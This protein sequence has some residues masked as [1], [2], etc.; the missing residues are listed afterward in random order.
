MSETRVKRVLL[1]EDSADDEHLTLR[2]LAKSAVPHHVDVARDG[3]EAVRYIEA[4]NSHSDMPDLILLDLKLPKLNGI[5]VLKRI[6]ANALTRAI[7]VVVLTSSDEESD[8][9]GC[10][11]NGANSYV[12]KPVE[13]DLFLKSVRSIGEF[14][15]E[16]A[17]LPSVAA[18][19]APPVVKVV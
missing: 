7:P 4:L 11:D 12:C 17:T 8:V 14:W 5:E 18:P 15:L 6:R 3:S 2:G 1:V 13:Y 9:R 10:Y 16:M 19:S